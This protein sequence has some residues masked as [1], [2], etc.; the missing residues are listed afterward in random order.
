MTQALRAGGHT[1]FQP[2]GSLGVNELCPGGRCQLNS[3]PKCIK[4]WLCWTWSSGGR[5]IW[6]EH[7]LA[8]MFAWLGADSF[9]CCPIFSDLVVCVCCKGYTPRGQRARP[10][11]YQEACLRIWFSPCGECTKLH[12]FRSAWDWIDSPCGTLCE[13]MT[14]V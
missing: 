7:S 10:T 12:R 4:S 6:I 11:T 5:A 1:F 14:Q 2:G 9:D 8:P 13:G 3:S